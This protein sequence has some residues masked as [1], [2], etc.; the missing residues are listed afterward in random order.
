MVRRNSFLCSTLFGDSSCLSYISSCNG[1][2]KDEELGMATMAAVTTATKSSSREM[3]TGT[4][5]LGNWRLPGQ[6][7]QVSQRYGG[8]DRRGEV[9]RLAG[10]RP[11]EQEPK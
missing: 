8:E 6:Q 4:R 9:T 10:Y 7:A 3:T 2:R 11:M 1:C 5:V